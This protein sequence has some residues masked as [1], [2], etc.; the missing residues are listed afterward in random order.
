M[1]LSVA[2]DMDQLHLLPIEI[3]MDIHR[4]LRI[5]TT[6]VPS[7]AYPSPYQNPPPQP[8]QPVQQ[9]PKQPVAPYQPPKST[10]PPPRLD[11]N[12][13]V[14]PAAM[15]SPMQQNTALDITTGQSVAI[16]PVAQAPFVPQISNAPINVGPVATSGPPAATPHPG[17]AAADVRGHFI[18]L[19][20]DEA[21]GRGIC[22][23]ALAKSG[24]HQL[25]ALN[26]SNAGAL[27]QAIVELGGANG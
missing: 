8:N 25:A 11:G 14:Y 17:V 23:A 7:A 27:W 10:G 4:A 21:R 2:V 16:P 20:Q 1:R 12:V 15:G 6:P 9:A 3:R 19:F 22:T 13:V 18:R 24:M 26:D 5:E